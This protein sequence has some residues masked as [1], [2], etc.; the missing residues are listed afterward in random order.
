MRGIFPPHSSFVLLIDEAKPL[1]LP[2]EREIADKKGK[3]PIHVRFGTCICR[4][5]GTPHRVGPPFIHV[6]YAL[7]QTELVEMVVELTNN[8]FVI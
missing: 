5:C 1:L 3:N 4:S 7:V 2:C 8:S 6:K